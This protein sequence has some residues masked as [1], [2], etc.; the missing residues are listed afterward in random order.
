MLAACRSFLGNDVPSP[1][2]PLRPGDFEFHESIRQCHKL[3]P[4]DWV[5]SP[6][7]LESFHVSAW[8]RVFVTSIVHLGLVEHSLEH[9]EGVGY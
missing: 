8:V 6:L 2:L 5:A 4:R 1:T 3:P 7:L 9:G